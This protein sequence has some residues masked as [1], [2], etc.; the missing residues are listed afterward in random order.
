[1]ADTSKGIKQ[2]T[3]TRRQAFSG[4]AAGT[5]AI[6]L[7]GPAG[8][9]E[10]I[11]WKMV[12]SWPKNLPGPGITAQLLADTITAMSGGRLAVKLFAAGELVPPLEAFSA[13]SEGVAEMAHTAPLFWAGKMSAAP[14]FTAAPFGLTPLEHITWITKGG[15]QELWDELYLP[16]GVKPFMAGNTGYQ[17]GGWYRNEIKSVDDFKGLKIRMPGLGGLVVQ[18]LGAVPVGL[19]PGEIFTSLQTGVIDATEFLGPF[20]DSA[21]GFHK[22]A[23][24]YYFPGFH[25]PNGTGEA[26]VS[27]AALD[28]LPSDLQ[29]IVAKAC[30][31]VNIRSLAD[32]EW[33]NA[34]ALKWL[35]EEQAVILQTFPDDVLDA[36]RK[37]TGEVMAALAAKDELTAR[38]VASYQNAAKHLGK[39]SDVSVKAFLEARG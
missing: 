14:I 19:A 2:M 9:T 1:M 25:E 33:E 24:N 6:A 17:M 32:A 18:K 26:L 11:H 16:A 28:G 29:D 35:Q 38:I 22:I 21:M 7:A 20:S 12:T 39:W 23:K 34:S 37:A 4:F 30:E 15:G 5:A 3:M 8:A 36:A 10:T 27:K 13:V 31:W